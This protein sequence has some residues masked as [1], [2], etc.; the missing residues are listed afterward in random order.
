M[1]RGLAA[2][3]VAIGR[4]ELRRQDAVYERGIVALKGGHPVALELFEDFL[5]RLD[6]SLRRCERGAEGQ[7]DERRC[8][9]SQRPTP[10]SQSVECPERSVGRWELG[11][12][13]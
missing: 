3:A 8:D 1:G 5:S 10:N 11:V 12:G 13:S 7:H 6:T 9:K 2:A 4:D